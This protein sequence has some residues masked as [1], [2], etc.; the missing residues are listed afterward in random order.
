MP[1]QQDYFGFDDVRTVSLPDGESYVEH[2][3]FT[4][5]ERRSYLN[6]INREVTIKKGGDATIQTAGGDARHALLETAVCGWNLL[7]DG[8]EFSFSRPN[9]RTFLDAASPRIID[10]VERDIQKANPWLMGEM[11]VEDIEE[12]I[13]NLE[14]MRTVIEERDE[15][16]ESS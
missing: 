9:L 15:G 2:K 12:E 13:Q 8:K 7:K 11:T 6:K 14:E 16:N 5:G 3:V 10:L 1:A 4:E